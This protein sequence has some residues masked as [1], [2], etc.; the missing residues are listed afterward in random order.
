MPSVTLILFAFSISHQSPLFNMIE[1]AVNAGG[2]GSDISI[3]RP[4][5]PYLK[6]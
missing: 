3:R 5:R 6:G 4:D 2:L 1:A